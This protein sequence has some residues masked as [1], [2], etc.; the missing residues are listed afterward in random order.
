MKTAAF[1]SKTEGGS[2][3]LFTGRQNGREGVPYSEKGASVAA[4]GTR[5]LNLACAMTV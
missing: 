1:G 5:D 3:C 4:L 2:P